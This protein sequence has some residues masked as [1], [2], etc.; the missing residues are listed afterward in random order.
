MVLGEIVGIAT[1]QDYLL[2]VFQ[3]ELQLWS[4]RQVLYQL[5]R[6]CKHQ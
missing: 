3:K 2:V 6:H 4:A 1:L 5:L